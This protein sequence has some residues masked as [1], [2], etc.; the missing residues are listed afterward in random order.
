V[1]N[2]Y[3]H[4]HHP[5]TAATNATNTIPG[6]KQSLHRQTHHPLISFRANQPPDLAPHTQTIHGGKSK[7]S[8]AADITR[9]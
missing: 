9:V 7:Q 6:Y 1:H 2:D 5:K 4:H 3:G 8:L